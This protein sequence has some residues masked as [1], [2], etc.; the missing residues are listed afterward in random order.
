MLKGEYKAL[1]GAS[2]PVYGLLVWKDNIHL[3][4]MVRNKD[5][6]LLVYKKY[7][8]VYLILQQYNKLMMVV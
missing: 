4:I 6:I 3:T 1:V 7:K 2:S 5:L 8:Y